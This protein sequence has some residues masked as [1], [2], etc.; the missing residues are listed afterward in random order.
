[1]VLGAHGRCGGTRPTAHSQ[2]GVDGYNGRKMTWLL[3]NLGLSV[4]QVAVVVLGNCGPSENK[5][6]RGRILRGDATKV[7]S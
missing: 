1:M 5:G 7:K 6:S 3:M 4:R 2:H